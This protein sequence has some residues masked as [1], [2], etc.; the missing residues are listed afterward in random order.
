MNEAD[1][2][3]GDQGEG[4]VR[5]E[6]GVSR[7]ISSPSC[8]LQTLL[9]NTKHKTIEEGQFDSVNYQLFKEVLINFLPSN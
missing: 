7:G 3:R 2:H 4:I 6:T 5:D 1:L 8:P 9:N